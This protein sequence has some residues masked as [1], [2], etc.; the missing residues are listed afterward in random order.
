VIALFDHAEHPVDI[1]EAYDR[2]I[3]TG[4]RMSRSSLYRLIADLVAAGLVME[5]RVGER[6][7]FLAAHKALA[8]RLEDGDGA[9]VEA[10]TS[11]LRALLTRMA[12]DAGLP[13]TGQATVVV[14]FDRPRA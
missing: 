7:R 3:A 10:E 6:R 8:C 13:L 11:E 1:D 9:A 12:F 2:V 5:L 14:R 4:G